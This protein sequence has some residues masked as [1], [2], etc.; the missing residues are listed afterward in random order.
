MKII[1][2]EQG[3][4]TWHETRLGKITAS[5]V[6][7]VMAVGKN[8]APLKVRSD[9]MM[10]L[11]CER[12]A[13][14]ASRNHVTPEMEWGSAEEKFARTAYEVRNSVDVVQHGIAIHRDFDWFAASPD[15][16]ING[17]GGVE[18][19]CPTTLTHLTWMLYGELPDDHL[20]QCHAIIDVW[21]LDFLDFFS[22]DSRLP[23]HLGEFQAPRLW[24]NDVKISEMHLGIKAFN[25]EL[26]DWIGTLNK[27]F[28]A[29]PPPQLPDD[30]EGLG[31][32]DAELND[33]CFQTQE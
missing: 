10:K 5:N 9:Y 7:N 8:G 16:I 13:H 28:P 20:W 1:K 14:N 31:L 29:P 22:Y 12:Y 11:L 15:G 25:Q 33:E 4:S 3:D 18:F 17:T 21:E 23:A 2:C 24:R 6:K 19:K 26:E 32:G 27:R 30:M